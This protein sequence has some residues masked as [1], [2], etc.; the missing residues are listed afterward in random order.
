MR[1]LM[2]NDLGT[3]TGGAELMT[4]ALSE[5]MR[6]RGHETLVLTS[7][8]DSHPDTFSDVECFGAKGGLGTVL[9]IANLSAFHVLQRTL[10]SFK[11]DVVHIRMFMTQLSPLILKTLRNIPTVYHAVSYETLCPTINKILPNGSF[12]EHT[13]G[14][15]CR[16]MDC[17]S[18]SA[19]GAAMV[20]RRQLMA[21]KDQFDRVVANG[22]VLAKDLESSGFSDVAIVSNGVQVM[23]QRSTLSSPPTITFA[24]RLVF[25]KGVDV[26]LRAFQTIQA[27]VGEAR[28][29]IVGGGP[30]A[31]KL[32]AMANDLSLRNVSWF[33]QVEKQRVA[34]I[35]D[36][37]WIHV[38][39]S[40]VETFG[41]SATEAMM[42]GT[43]VVASRVGGL[44]DQVEDGTTGILCP[45][46][47]ADALAA[48][49]I[50]LLQ[51]RS[52]CEQMGLAARQR[53][54]KFFAI[55]RCAGEF[56]EIYRQMR[57]KTFKSLRRST[58]AK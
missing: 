39:P 50:T 4:L 2:M 11:P 25:L 41:I 7:N 46:A 27:E 31:C 58:I 13:A 45:I 40:R 44:I 6:Q 47:D 21:W 33:G 51:D 16:K 28:L 55:D 26:L 24:G 52:R 19:W 37:S 17:L 30:E 14:W 29:Q 38:V 10:D 18:L 12:C 43:L 32:K 57:V 56:E 53:A 54:L 3:P 22:T 35:C 15:I 1:I 42:R 34:E 8:A 48:A 20:Q 49:M 23:P 9:K 36:D 5:A